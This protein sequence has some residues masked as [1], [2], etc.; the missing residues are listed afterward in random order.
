MLDIYIGVDMICATSINDKPREE[1]IKKY[2]QTIRAL[3]DSGFNCEENCLENISCEKDLINSLK[4]G[5]IDAGLI[6]I[7]NYLLNYENACC[8]DKLMR[9][10]DAV[11]TWLGK[12]GSKSRRL[13]MEDDLK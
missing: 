9:E 4:D 2:T 5:E 1:S 7:C 8:M 10:Q 12:I 6:I 13:N 3:R 11:Y